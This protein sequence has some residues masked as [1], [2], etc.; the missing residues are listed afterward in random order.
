MQLVIQSTMLSKRLLKFGWYMILINFNDNVYANKWKDLLLDETVLYMCVDSNSTFTLIHSE[1]LLEL[2]ETT[3]NQKNSIATSYWWFTP[4][5]I[6]VAARFSLEMLC[7][8][9]VIHMFRSVN[10]VYCSL[11]ILMWDCTGTTL[12]I[13]EYYLKLR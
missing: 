6:H 9:A 7:L 3:W 8:T 4:S 13:I 12:K 10:C 2:I 1:S 11:L 5:K